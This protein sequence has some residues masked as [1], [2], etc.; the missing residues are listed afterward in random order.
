MSQ[1]GRDIIVGLT[2]IAGAA[3]IAFLT[4]IF[5]YAPGWLQDG[6]NVTLTMPH[7]SGLQAGSRVRMSGKD[8][9]RIDSVALRGPPAWGVIV[10]AK[11]D[12][13]YDVPVA[14]LIGVESPILGGSPALSLEPRRG[15]TGNAAAFLVKDGSARLEITDEIPSLASRFAAELRSALKATVTDLRAELGRAQGNLDRLADAWVAVAEHL[16]ALLEPRTPAMV[17]AADTG[18]LVGNLSTVLARADERL[19]ELQLVLDG[20]AVWVNDPTLREQVRALAAN[21]NQLAGKLEHGVDRV[22]EIAQGT[23]DSF[24]TLVAALVEVSDELSQAITG[25]RTVLAR[26]T[27]G[28]GTAARLL[29]DPAAYE[30]MQDAFERLGLALEEMRMLV[31]KWQREGLP[32]KF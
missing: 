13:L 15:K 18:G 30:S 27:D 9:G 21:A 10:A 11:I 19:A 6:Y 1:R 26:V 32:V 7:A 29:N 8:I 28:K 12:T 14:V 5:G 3:G 4:L 22:T 31:E 17:D 2:G 20:I 24:D 25:A 16:S 23:A